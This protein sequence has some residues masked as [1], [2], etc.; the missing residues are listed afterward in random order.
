MAV[1]TLR[2][3]GLALL[4]GALGATAC[5]TVDPAILGAEALARGDDAGAIR[6]LQDATA[7]TPDNPKA[8]RDLARAHFRMGHV[9]AAA[10]AIDQATK[11]AP[12]DPDVVL[13]RAQIRMNGGDR[14]GAG[15]DATWML[16]HGRT[17][18]QLE[19]TAVLLV[20]LGRAR[21]AVQAAS[22]VVELS[23]GSASSYGNR[24]VLALEL[25]QVEVADRALRE[26]RAAHPKDIKLAQTQAAFF[27]AT[28]QLD[29]AREV[30]LQIL[31]EHPQPGLIHQA[32]ALLA[33]E[34][35]DLDDAQ[36]HADA[37]VA[38]LGMTRAD[39]LYTQVVIY[40]DRG[41]LEAAQRQLR[42]ARRRFPAHEDLAAL[43]RELSPAS[44]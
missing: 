19:Q 10:R 18:S 13:L 26:G 8:W 33:H 38:A 32:L 6:Y 9:L 12:D 44:R 24:A 30:Y 5:A 4:V 1:A 22:K 36:R 21:E 7:Q 43:E 23:G 28:Q 40:R 25:R 27:L 34:A 11:L 14:E 15:K 16:A 31:P 37:A 20:R 35:G 3:A 39:V 41:D 17:P 42:K 2:L 29:R